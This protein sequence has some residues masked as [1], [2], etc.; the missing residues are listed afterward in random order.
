MKISP[1][2]NSVPRVKINA[3]FSA[4]EAAALQKLLQKLTVEDCRK[5]ADNDD[6]ASAFA[7]A[8]SKMRRQIN[9]AEELPVLP[10]YDD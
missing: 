9:A 7:A 10:A 1:A 5:L 6:E 2:Q 4:E 8:A 3:L